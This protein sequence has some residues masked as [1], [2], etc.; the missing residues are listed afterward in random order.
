MSRG[1]AQPSRR[2]GRGC[3]SPPPRSRRKAKAHAV[4]TSATIA[5]TIGRNGHHF[6]PAN[7]RV[8]CAHPI[9]ESHEI[10][11]SP[12]SPT[13][14][15]T[16]AA[17]S[18]A[19]AIPYTTRVFSLTC[20]ATSATHREDQPEQGERESERDRSRDRK[21]LGDQR[22]RRPGRPRS[23]SSPRRPAMQPQSAPSYRPAASAAARGG[24]PPPRRG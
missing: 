19:P 2:P 5:A 9:G 23:R 1:P 21:T 3:T 24:R 6:S 11:P 22:E 17:P 15:S 14:R 12:M 7:G 10:V 20:A 8:F 4:T 16:N 13:A 18:T